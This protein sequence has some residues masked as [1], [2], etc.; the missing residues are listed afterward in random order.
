MHK[1][2][3]RYNHRGRQVAIETI[4][5]GSNPNSLKVKVDASDSRI[6]YTTVRSRMR[7]GMSEEEAINT[8]L[9]RQKY[10]HDLSRV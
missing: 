10:V 1:F 9:M 2:R 7:A 3:Y 4:N 6:P 8:P 5:G